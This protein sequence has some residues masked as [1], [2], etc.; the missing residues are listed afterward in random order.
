[1]QHLLVL[2]VKA[3]SC[4]GCRRY[5]DEI[6]HCSKGTLSLVGKTDMGGMVWQTEGVVFANGTDTGI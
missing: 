3:T 4:R 5:Q 6:R 1:M 2:H